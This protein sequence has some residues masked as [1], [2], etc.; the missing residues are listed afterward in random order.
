MRCI[1]FAFSFCPENT[2][3]A[4]TAECVRAREHRQKVR[5]VTEAKIG[6]DLPIAF[7]V[8]SLEII[9]EATATTN[10]FQQALPAVVILRVRPE[11]TGKVVDVIREDRNL[12]LRRACIGLVRAV[13]F[14]CRGLL[15]CHV[16]VFSARVARWVSLNL[17]KP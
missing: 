11:V 14:D 12:N 6:D 3:R 15:K 17:R 2:K 4:R 13:L 7:D 9:E 10:H 8:G 16:A 1:F 5:L